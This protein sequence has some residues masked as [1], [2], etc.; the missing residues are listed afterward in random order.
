MGRSG[1]QRLLPFLRSVLPAA[2]VMSKQGQAKFR[3][4]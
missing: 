1:R 2:V 3:V 4:G